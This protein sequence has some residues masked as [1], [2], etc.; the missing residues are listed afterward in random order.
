MIN[1]LI[2]TRREDFLL[3]LSNFFQHKFFSRA[4]VALAVFIFAFVNFSL[5]ASAARRAQETSYSASSS[6]STR[7]GSDKS[8][9]N[10]A[11]NNATNN[12]KNDATNDAMPALTDIRFGSTDAR[13]RI[14]FDA[15]AWPEYKVNEYNGGKRIVIELRGVKNKIKKQSAIKSDII[16]RVQYQTLGDGL[17]MTIDLSEPV[18]Y[19]VKKLKNPYRLFIDFAKEYERE[20]SEERAPGLTLTKYE[21]RDARGLLTAYFLDVDMNKYRLAPILAN[22]I[23][24]GRETVSDMSDDLDAVAAVNATYFETNG[25]IIGLMRM[26]GTLVGTTYFTRSSLG[27]RRDGSAF[28]APAYYAATVTIGKASHVVSGVNIERGD[29]NLI[30]YNKNYGDTTGTNRYGREF[31]VVNG[32]VAK[33]QQANSEIPENGYVISVH[34]EARNDFARVRVGDKVTLTEDYGEAFND[35]SKVPDVLGAGPTLVKN[36]AV[37]V[38]ADDED[39]PADIAKGRAPR[40]GV[41]I[42]ANRHMMLAVVDG[43]QKSSIGATLTEFAELLVARGARDAINFD[44][45][46]SSEMVVGGEIINSPSDGSERPVGSALG[47]FKR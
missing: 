10:G 41:A 34:G 42:M 3:K 36:G 23:V 25:E 24:Q 29:D 22:G 20:T 39:F 15:E 12:A 17:R 18:E 45:G 37:N 1:W 11:S 8:R 31:I 44:G 19:E 35:V 13:D 38:T 46:G 26:D 47:V 27:L 32:K 33:I 9:D 14:V 30:I 2:I 16:E 4:A 40:T 28:I 21:R 7:H 6:A 5:T 43:R